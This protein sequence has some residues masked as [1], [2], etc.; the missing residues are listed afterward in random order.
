MAIWTLYTNIWVCL[1]KVDFRVPNSQTHPESVLLVNY[2]ELYL[3][4]IYIYVNI[5]N[6]FLELIW[7]ITN[8]NIMKYGSATAG[9]QLSARNL[10]R[11][12]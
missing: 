11:G 8:Y 9:V 2:G 6:E 7:L 1:E 3:Y 5:V 10:S 12:E 4:N